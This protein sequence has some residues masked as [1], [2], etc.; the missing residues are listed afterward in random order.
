MTFDSG[1][2]LSAVALCLA[3]LAAAMLIGFLVRRPPLTRVVKMWLFVALG[4]LP[5]SAAMA[6]NIAN[7]E[8]TTKRKFCASCHTMDPHANDAA[9]PH[10]TS[11]ASI[12]S[13]NPYFGDKS[14]Y[15]CHADYGMF[16]TVLTKIGGMHHVWDYYTQDWDAPGHRPPQ[17]YKPYSNLACMQCHPVDK[18][19]Q[20]LEHKIHAEAAKKDLVSCAA[21][22]CHGPPH[23]K[24]K[25]I[26]QAA[27]GSP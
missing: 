4:P 23:P 20:P 1:D 10:S 26:V 15:V 19:R 16:G 24:P 3:L 11:L 25:A 13:K 9:D 21:A 14:C 6:G 5:I 12:H 7:F 22:N 17:L 18:P 8:V 27:G 2:L